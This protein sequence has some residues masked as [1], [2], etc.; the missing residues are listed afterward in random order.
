MMDYFEAQFKKTAA[1]SLKLLE[2]NL[3]RENISQLQTRLLF[4]K[5]RTMKETN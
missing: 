1:N 3:G 2:V 5:R 4:F